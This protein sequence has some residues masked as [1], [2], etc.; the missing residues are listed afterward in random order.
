MGLAGPAGVWVARVARIRGLAVPPG[1]TTGLPG[2]S[3]AGGAAP[4]PRPGVA[5]GNGGRTG[6]SGKVAVLFSGSRGPLA[7]PFASEGMGLTGVAGTVRGPATDRLVGLRPLAPRGADVS[8]DIPCAAPFPSPALGI[9]APGET[10]PPGAAGGGDGPAAARVL[11]GRVVAPG[12]GLVRGFSGG[13]SS[14]TG[15]RSGVPPPAILSE[16]CKVMGTRRLTPAG[17]NL[18]EV[19]GLAAEEPL[20]G[21]LT[22]GAGRGGGRSRL[23]CR[24]SRIASAVFPSTELEWVFFSSI[25]TWGRIARI[26]PALTSSS[27]A[28]SLI[29][30]FCALSPKTGLTP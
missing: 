22:V 4:A 19:A 20:G 11:G 9:E 17:F 1:G 3:W 18:G 24:K 23:L 30:I 14:R 6:P 16:G 25:P 28:N 2:N 10:C 21:E 15:G 7:W 29:R 13:R 27:R 26:A 5:G 12:P 8:G